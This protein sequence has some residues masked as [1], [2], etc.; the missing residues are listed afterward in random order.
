M[1]HRLFATTLFSLGINLVAF[2]QQAMSTTQFW[3][4][5]LHNNPAVAGLNYRHEA[6]ALYRNQ[7]DGVNGAPNGL[8]VNYSA[9]VDKIHG[10]AGISYDLDAIGFNRQ[11]TVLA[12]YAFHLPIKSSILSFGVSAGTMTLGIKPDWVPPTTS[13]DPALPQESTRTDFTSNVGVAFHAPQWNAGFSISMLNEPFFR[14]ANN[15]KFNT[16]R[17][18]WLYADY[19]YNV[20]DHFSLKPQIQFI[21]DAVKITHNACV[22]AQIWNF[23][24]GITYSHENYVGGIIGYD[25]K[26]KYRI[27]YGYDITTNKLSSVSK[28]SHEIVLSYLLK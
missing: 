3:S 26:G 18:Y 20:T 15:V 14:M 11:H 22:R 23:W 19:T 21:T 10:A 6:N 24:T 12:H 7:W 13:S 4:T 1:N 17:H 27:G 16:V 25:F 8:F 9:K 5:N 2:S 28:G